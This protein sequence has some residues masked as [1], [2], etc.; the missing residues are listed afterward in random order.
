MLKPSEID[1][2]RYFTASPFQNSECETILRNIIMLQKNK[3]PD[4]WK[5]FSWDDYLDLYGLHKY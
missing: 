1:T 3:N 4:E 5:K 2:N